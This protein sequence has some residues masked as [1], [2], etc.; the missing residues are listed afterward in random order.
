[1]SD[2]G[3]QYVKNV[4]ASWT[5]NA[6]R[7]A[8]SFFFVP[9]LTSVLGDDRY[10]VWIILF[11][12]INYFTLLD[13]GITSSITRFVSK[14][15]AK[16]DFKSVGRVLSTSGVMFLIVG[17]LAGIGILIFVELGFG[18]FSISGVELV[19]EGKIALRILGLYMALNFWMMPFGGS[20]AAFQRHDVTSI[21]GISEELLRMGIMVWLLRNGY[22]L[23]SLAWTL[24]GTTLLRNLAGMV[25]LKLK[26][27]KLQLGYR[28]YDRNTKKE[29]LGYSKISFAIGL[30]W[31]VIFNTDAILLG[32]MTSS[33]IAGVYHAGAQI[34]LHVRNI[35]NGLAIPLTPAI[36]H[37]DSKSET[38]RVREVGLKGISYVSYL[39]FFMGTMIFVYARP[40]VSLWLPAEFSGSAEV[41]MIFAFGASFFM[42]FI[43]GNSILYGTG[44]HRMLLICLIVEVITKIILSIILIPRM[45]MIG[46]ALAASLPQIALYTTLYPLMLSSVLGCRYW[47]VMMTVGRSAVLAILFTFPL[48]WLLLNILPPITWTELIFDGAIQTMVWLLPGWWLIMNSDDRLRVSKLFSRKDEL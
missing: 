28:Q 21:L 16:D 15:L 44:Q 17:A 24:V 23:E 46:M 18:L 26:F 19:T 27:P 7:F 42:P 1:M 9:F 36:S 38:A 33:A 13:L 2:L 14:Y 3:H 25:W 6:I 11:Q 48:S 12:T 34:F 22:G 8:I 45:G 20:L 32:V 47:R 29:L 10:G 4:S 41:M 39:S 31:L 35:V 5:H 43:I 30:C 40:F 37:L